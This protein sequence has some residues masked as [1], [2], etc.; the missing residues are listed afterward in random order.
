MQKWVTNN[1]L[2]FVLDGRMGVAELKN[3][4]SAKRLVKHMKSILTP[5]IIVSALT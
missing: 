4:P 3:K 5:I 1:Y 2:V